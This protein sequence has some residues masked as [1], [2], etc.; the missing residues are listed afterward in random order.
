MMERN[1]LNRVLG[2]MPRYFFH[3]H[4]NIGTVPDEEGQELAGVG[5][6]R[7]MAIVAIRSVLGEELSHGE[8]DLNGRIDV[9]DEQGKMVLSISYEEAVAIRHAFGTK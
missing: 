1:R 5:R 4:N 2:G 6:A 9:T 7:D 8:I 3:L